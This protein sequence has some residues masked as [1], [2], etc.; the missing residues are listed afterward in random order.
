MKKDNSGWIN[1][2]KFNPKTH[3]PTPFKVI[4]KD[5][6][7]SVV[8][9]NG[10]TVCSCRNIKDAEF[11]VE[12]CNVDTGAIKQILINLDK[13]IIDEKIKN[14]KLELEKDGIIYPSI[15]DRYYCLTCG[16]IGKEHPT[17]GMCFICGDD[18]WDVVSGK[19]NEIGY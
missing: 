6:W 15:D 9:A 7:H 8:A 17:T 5:L 10:K 11:I 14:N 4:E 19:E 16:N 3:N 1:S 2:K 12:K 18:N 13:K